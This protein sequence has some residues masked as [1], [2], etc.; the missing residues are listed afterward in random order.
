MAKSVDLKINRAAVR[1][2]LKDPKVLADLEARGR[3]IAAA[4]GSGVEV[5]S[6]VGQTRARVT[7][8]TV[9][10]AARYREATERTLTSAVD[11]GR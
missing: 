6:Y 1:D 8:R 3:R 11:A 5:Q 2:L 9:T 4:A 7:V 10:W